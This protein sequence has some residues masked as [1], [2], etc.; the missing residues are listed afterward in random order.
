MR[1]LKVLIADDDFPTVEMLCNEID[2][3]ARGITEIL[4]A[5]NGQMAIDLIQEEQ[6]EIILCDIGMP[7]KSGMEVLEWI[8]EQQ[9]QPYFIFLTCYDT[10]EYAK[11]AVALHAFHY[12]TKPCALEEVCQAVSTAVQSLNNRFSAA[13]KKSNVEVLNLLFAGSLPAD[14]QKLRKLLKEGAAQI[15]ADASYYLVAASVDCRRSVSAGWEEALFKY[16]F[17]HLLREAILDQT[18]SDYSVVFERDYRYTLIFFANAEQFQ[19]QGL[20]ERCTQAVEICKKSLACAPVVLV[21][22]PM[23]LWDVSQRKGNFLSLLKK[24]SL[25][26]GVVEWERNL[27]APENSQK[28]RD[29]QWD[30]E[31]LQNFM[32]QWDLEGLIAYLDE[33]LQKALEQNV[34]NSVNIMHRIHQ[35]LLQVFYILLHEQ[36]V[37][38]SAVFDSPQAYQLN[39][40]AE[41]SK[42]TMLEFVSFMLTRTHELTVGETHTPVVLDA[43]AYIEQNYMRDISRDDVAKAAC[44]T[45]N[46]LSK[47]FHEETGQTIREYITE[48]RMR[49]AKNLL[50]NTEDTISNIAI[51]TGFGNISYFST[52]FRK[53]YRISPFLWRKNNR[54]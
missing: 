48:C 49:E 28:T 45:P 51:N 18:S 16:A 20:R 41:S 27:T 14:E 33:F 22:E 34:E 38:A 17:R 52:L 6:P 40:E 53:K 9:L 36:K 23:H 21:S 26:P 47:L 39:N 13:E 5:Y 8:N 10:F 12:L 31:R 7:I 11:Q 32:E 15:D 2:W 35:D 54:H 44:V 4:R 42:E 30:K 19:E 37:D 50:R 29:L 24:V 25:Y 46:Y 43:V 1:N 3:N